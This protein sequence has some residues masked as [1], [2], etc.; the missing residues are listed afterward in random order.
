MAEPKAKRPHRLTADEQA[1]IFKLRT[2]GLSLRAIAARTGRSKDAVCDL[3]KKH[4]IDFHTL[5]EE[6]LMEAKDHFDRLLSP[7]WIAGINARQ[8]LRIMQQADIVLSRID[9]TLAE[10]DPDRFSM[11]CRA[12]NSLSSALA[13]VT[14][15]NESLLPRQTQ[16]SAELPELTVRIMTESDVQQMRQAQAEE[17]KLLG[18]TE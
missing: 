17:A 13:T 8:S 15:I 16:E 1:Q 14:K 6:R 18:I 7:E 4:P 9:M 3:L 11:E 5:T 10:T 12:L 2:A